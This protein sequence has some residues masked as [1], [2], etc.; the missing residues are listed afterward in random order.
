MAKRNPFSHLNKLIRRAQTLDAL[1]F[2]KRRAKTTYE[3]ETSNQ[4]ISWLYRVKINNE[5]KKTLELL[6]E[7]TEKLR[8]RS[9]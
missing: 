3:R 9:N 4:N 5:Y 8:R 7:K 2:L 6:E 1:D